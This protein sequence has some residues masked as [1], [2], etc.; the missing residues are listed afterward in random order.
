MKW[1][2]SKPCHRIRTVKMRTENCRQGFFI[3]TVGTRLMINKA[4]ER[5]LHWCSYW[6]G[7]VCTM[8]V[9]PYI[10]FALGKFISCIPDYRVRI[11][12]WVN[13]VICIT[14]MGGNNSMIK[15]IRFFACVAG[16][17]LLNFD[18]HFFSNYHGIIIVCKFR[19]SASKI[20]IF[21]LSRSCN[22][23]DNSRICVVLYFFA[24][25]V[26]SIE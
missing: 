4:L 23:I 22:V 15:K 26:L 3:L 5:N 21:Q 14:N 7:C 10:F 20:F 8:F 24:W 9:L 2:E 6:V 25:N 17:N 13:F 11:R 18:L 19:V 16:E 12:F 1:K